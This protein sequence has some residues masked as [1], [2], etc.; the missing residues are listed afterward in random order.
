M[1]EYYTYIYLDTRK[2]GNYNYNEYHFDFEPFYV[3]KGS[4]NRYLEHL[5]E[6]Y[7]LQN[8]EHRH[9]KIRKIIR[10][11]GDKPIIL[12]VKENLTEEKSV[13]LEIHLIKIIGRE[14]LGLGPLLNKTDGGEGLI[15]PGQSTRELMSERMKVWFSIPENKAKIFTSERAKKISNAMSGRKKSPEHVA[16]LPQN[17]KGYKHTE[18]F[19]IKQRESAIKSLEWR[20]FK[21]FHEIWINKYGK[22]K[23]DEMFENYKNKMSEVTLGKNN[24]M[25]GKSVHD[26]WTEKY[27]IQIADEKWKLSNEKR[28]ITLT[29]RKKSKEWKKKASEAA[30][31]RWQREREKK[32]K[33]IILQ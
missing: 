4:N 12:K 24:P 14:D 30:K 10:E 22:I 13:E 18:E 16:K 2:P 6:S 11:T 26:A 15:N 3:G 32:I 9:R 21:P 23:A 28:S 1:N 29:G 25:Y 33:T 8:D 20:E 7:D 5:N 17:Q 31:K 27:G 19:K